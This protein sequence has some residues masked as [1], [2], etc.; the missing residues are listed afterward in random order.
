[1]RQ[2]ATRSGTTVSNPKTPGGSASAPDTAAAR[3]A[4]L[5]AIALAASAGAPAV[6]SRLGGTPATRPSTASTM[7]SIRGCTV[8]EYD[9]IALSNTLRRTNQ[10]TG[11]NRGHKP[12]GAE[13]TQG[14]ACVR[15]RDERTHEVTA[16]DPAVFEFGRCVCRIRR[17]GHRR[18][19]HR[20]CADRERRALGE[21]RAHRQHRDT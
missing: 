12:R 18:C 4:A 2:I 8:S 7:L 5:R 20:R 21:G 16:A 3:E 13:W 1:M 17:R 6:F 9:V 19:G 14:D 10:Y 15:R 11:Y